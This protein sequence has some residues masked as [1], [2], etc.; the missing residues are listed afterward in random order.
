M[1]YALLKPLFASSTRLGAFAIGAGDP[2]DLP[3]VWFIDFAI[4]WLFLNG[5]PS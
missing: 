1:H 2:R 4:A 3:S 5:L